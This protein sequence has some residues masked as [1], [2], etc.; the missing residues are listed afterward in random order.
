M[1]EDAIRQLMLLRLQLR[2]EPEMTR[3]IHRRLTAGPTGALPVIGSDARTGIAIRKIITA[4]DF[5]MSSSPP[6]Q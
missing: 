6:P 1:S 2:V 4:G 5:A 3:Y